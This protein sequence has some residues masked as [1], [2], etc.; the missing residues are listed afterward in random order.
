MFTGTF[1]AKPRK[2]FPVGTDHMFLGTSAAKPGSGIGCH[3]GHWS[4]RDEQHQKIHCKHGKPVS[5]I[6]GKRC[7][8]RFFWLVALVSG[9]EFKAGQNGKI[10][11]KQRTFWAGD[12]L[13]L[14]PRCT[15]VIKGFLPVT[16]ASGKDSLV[17]MS[18]TF[19]TDV[20]E[21]ALHK[22]MLSV[23]EGL[24]KGTTQDDQKDL[25]F[26]LLWWRG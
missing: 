9:E 5:K 4:R 22:E 12:V 6:S 19:G 15:G 1:V 8:L 20:H 24:E 21:Q 14:R 17:R 7:P 13:T 2:L 11:L 25:G 16:W 3:S 26:W 18:L 10:N 23:L